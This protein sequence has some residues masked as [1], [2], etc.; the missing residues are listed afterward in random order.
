MFI[1]SIK[2]DVDFFQKPVFT[3]DENIVY[4]GAEGKVISLRTV[5]KDTP[6]VAVILVQGFH[7]LIAA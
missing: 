7:G 3:W 4:L 5:I 2:N 1:V 6:K